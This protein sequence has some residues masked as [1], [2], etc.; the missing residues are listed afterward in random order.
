MKTKIINISKIYS[1]DTLNKCIDIILRNKKIDSIMTV[2]KIYSWFW[3][4]NK[5]VNYNPKILPRSQDAAPVIQETTGLYGIK[6]NSLKKYKCRIGKKP[7]F[8]PVNK[9]EALDLDTIE[10]F[11]NLKNYLRR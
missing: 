4:K 8:Y 10:D 1:W 11:K 5:P 2:N 6:K 9:K 3:H 7:Y